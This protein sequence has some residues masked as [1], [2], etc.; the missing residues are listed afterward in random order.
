MIFE[1]MSELASDIKIAPK[2]CDEIY[3]Q[4]C[5]EY[6]K[7]IRKQKVIRRCVVSF[8]AVFL[9][10]G[11]YIFVPNINH[12]MVYA[13]GLNGQVQLKK[14]VKVELKEEM[15]PL[16]RGYSFEI[17]LTEGQQYQVI[18]GM[19]NENAQ[20]I[21]SNK[22][23]VY[24]IPDGIFPYGIKS[25]EG[26]EIQIGKTDRSVLQIRVYEGKESEDILLVLERN[27]NGDFVELIENKK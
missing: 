27:E 18:E 15:T 23:I 13:T 4:C 9:V 11:L 8:L 2:E 1:S 20:N 21:F 5:V 7:R 19:G 17:H 26:T 25:E 6:E 10:A 22:N 24:W 16:G 3:K 12:T 14:G